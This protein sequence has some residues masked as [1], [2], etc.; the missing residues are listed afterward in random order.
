MDAGQDASYDL[1]CLVS[2]ATGD[3]QFIELE[4]IVAE[5]QYTFNAALNP[6]QATETPFMEIWMP[7]PVPENERSNEEPLWQNPNYQNW[8]WGVGDFYYNNWSNRYMYLQSF[9]NL[10]TVDFWKF[11]VYK[12]SQPI[13]SIEKFCLI[14]NTVT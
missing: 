1:V 3:G 13:E 4:M 5:T 8:K 14:R 7:D 9:P 2:Q 12:L 11:T 10:N 6:P